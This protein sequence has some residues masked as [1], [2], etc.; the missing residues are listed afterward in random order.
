[1]DGAKM[2]L[3]PLSVTVV[4]AWA[5]FTT[6]VFLVCSILAYYDVPCDLCFKPADI[7][8][9]VATAASHVA[10]SALTPPRRGPPCP[11]VRR[12]IAYLALSLAIVVHFI[13]I[14]A[15]DTDHIVRICWTIFFLAGDLVCFL[16][17]LLGGDD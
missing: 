6:S 5:L 3:L 13:L 2:R 7:T 12:A 14:F 11:R 17:L 8:G 16:A 10:A 4:S 1:M 15:T 9:I